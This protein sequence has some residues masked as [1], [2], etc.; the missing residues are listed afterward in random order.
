M[1]TICLAFAA[2]AILGTASA[3]SNPNDY[4]PFHNEIKPWKIYIGGKAYSGCN[5]PNWVTLDCIHPYSWTRW[6]NG[7]PG[8]IETTWPWPY[9]WYNVQDGTEVKHYPTNSRVGRFGT[10]HFFIEN[11]DFPA[12]TGNIPPLVGGNP[13]QSLALPYDLVSFHFDDVPCE[14]GPPAGE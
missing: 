4:N 6:E 7:T 13:M 1:R 9:I 3:Q 2:M 14:S 10:I 8:T 11:H 12:K 5:G